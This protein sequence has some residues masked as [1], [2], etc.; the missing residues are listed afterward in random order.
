MVVTMEALNTYMAGKTLAEQ[1]EERLKLLKMTKA[2][3]AMRM[4]YSR[5]AISQYVGGKY[6]SDPTELEK[7][8]VEFLEESGG[9]AEN[10]AESRE[11]IAGSTQIPRLK[12][13]TEFFESRDF[14]QAIGVC[15]ACQENTGLGIIVGKPGQGKTHALKKYAK[16]PR[17]VYIEGNETMN[18]KDIIRRIEKRIGMSRSYGSIDERM[19]NIIE[20]FNVNEGYLI[21]MD[22]ADKL[23]NKY[24]IKKLELLRNITDAAE[25]GLVIAGEPVLETLLKTYDKRFTDRMDF[26][27]KLRGLTPQEVKDYLEGYE[28]DDAAM[29]EMISRATNAQRGCFRLLDR[30]LSNVLRVLKQKGDTK[31][32][33][34][35]V[36]EASA[37]MM[38]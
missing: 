31:I 2:E 35:N 22:E 16:L 32:T 19:E 37:M 10:G 13:K 36:S 29:N 33:M 9:M 15:Q 23:I 5:S 25:V 26:Y 20:F 30:T 8:I 17:V 4:N 34:K 1:L 12:K 24:T 21:I 11:R 14:M 7:K 6:Q 18:C 3:A 28:V 27:Y 38:L